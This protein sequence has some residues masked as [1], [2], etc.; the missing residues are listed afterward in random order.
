[1]NCKR[2]HHTDAAHEPSSK[3]HSVIKAGRCLIPSCSCRQYLD[4]IDEIDEELI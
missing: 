4:P 3:S 1:M 2:C